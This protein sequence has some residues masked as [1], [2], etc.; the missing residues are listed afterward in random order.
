MQD[1]RIREQRRHR[2]QIELRQANRLAGRV[3]AGP[4]GEQGRGQEIDGVLGG[5]GVRAGG[6][7][8]VGLERPVG[9]AV[10]GI[11]GRRGGSAESLV[12]MF[13]LRWAEQQS[14]ELAGVGLAGDG[15]ECVAVVKAETVHEAADRLCGSPR[16]RRGRRG[17]CRGTQGRPALRSTCGAQAKR[18]R[19]AAAATRCFECAV[20]EE[21]N[22][23]RGRKIRKDRRRCRPAACA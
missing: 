6:G 23:E 18:A 17:A 5:V 1:R 10:V 3:V 2:T 9:G 20:I 14:A 22:G 7:D 8:E 11:G 12:T 15:V 19:A 21:G 4:L 16:V 13:C